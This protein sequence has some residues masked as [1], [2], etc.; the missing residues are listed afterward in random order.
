MTITSPPHTDNYP[1]RTAQPAQPIDTTTAKGAA[2]V[3]GRRSANN[4]TATSASPNPSV[5]R[6]SVAIKTTVTT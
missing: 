6:I 5:E 2:T 3:K 4:G 1:T